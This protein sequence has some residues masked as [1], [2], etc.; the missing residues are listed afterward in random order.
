MVMSSAARNRL[1]MAPKRMK[2]MRAL[3]SL[4]PEAKA[5]AT[6]SSAAMGGS[7]CLVGGF[8]V[9]AVLRPG[10]VRARSMLRRKHGRVKV[11]SGGCYDSGVIGSIRSTVFER[12]WKPRTV[13]R[14]R[15]YPGPE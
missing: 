10:A 1:S 9:E 2:A 8:Q 7:G 15:D 3:F 11:G 14:Q 6:S 13:Q 4:C 5:G 12:H